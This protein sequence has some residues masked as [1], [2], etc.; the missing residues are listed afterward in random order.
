MSRSRLLGLHW[1]SGT[2]QL[3][4]APLS[5]TMGGMDD[6]RRLRQFT[7]LSQQDKNRFE[8]EW[9]SSET[10][11]E[12]HVMGAIADPIDQGKQSASDSAGRAVCDGSSGPVPP[13][14]AA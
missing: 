13:L 9:C 2:I 10:G 3:P 11:L 14:P 1:Q 7:K 12:T 4:T 8:L 6:I 5:A